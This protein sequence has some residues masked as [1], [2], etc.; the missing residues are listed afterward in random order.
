VQVVAEFSQG[1]IA[2]VMTM[3]V[4]DSLK[5]VDIEK[6]QAEMLV[7]PMRSGTLVMEIMGEI[8]PILE[9]DERVVYRQVA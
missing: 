6:E 5:I 2:D 9:T 3:L 7:S 1:H 4:I 8:S